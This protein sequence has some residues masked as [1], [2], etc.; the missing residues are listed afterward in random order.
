MATPPKIF[1]RTRIARRLAG[2]RGQSD[3]VTDLVIADLA[4]RL[5]TITRTF[6]KAL[7]LGPDASVLPRTGRSAEGAFT[8]ARRSTLV[9]GP[10][11]PALDPERFAS[12]RPHDLI[13]SLLDLQAVNDVPGFLGGLRNHLE[14]DGLLIAAA[15]GGRTLTEMREAWLAAD[16]ELSGGAAPRVAP[17]IDVRDA[18]GLLQRAG[19]A[20]P[21]TDLETHTV[22]YSDPIALFQ[23]V[24]ALGASNP[25][26]E[27][28]P[29]PTTRT[30][31]IRAAEIYAQR[32]SDPDGRVRAT[33]EILWLSGWAP[34]ESQ[35]KPLQPGSAQ[36][37]L[38]DVLGDKG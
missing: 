5:G 8:F 17:M 25:L 37:S 19:F 31:L 23:E 26:L 16:A 22:R 36:K 4:D 2:R 28:D 13:V 6:S 10:D 21:V 3:F 38:R 34:H 32:F 27:R 35:Q 12:D 33:L 18:G 7:I 11:G 20:L 29:R 30:R 1:D 15:I 9:P 24:R 14:P